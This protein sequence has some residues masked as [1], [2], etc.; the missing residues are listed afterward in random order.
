[1]VVDMAIVDVTKTVLA[2]EQSGTPGAQEF[3]V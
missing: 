1:M 2:V 3:T